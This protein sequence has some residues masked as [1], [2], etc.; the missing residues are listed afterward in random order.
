MVQESGQHLNKEECETEKVPSFMRTLL[1]V[2]LDAVIDPLASRGVPGQKEGAVGDT[3]TQYSSIRR[4]G[5][6]VMRSPV[7]KLMQIGP[8]S[9]NHARH[10]LSVGKLCEAAVGQIVIQLISVPGAGEESEVTMGDQQGGNTGRSL[11]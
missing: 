6:V 7:G 9:R 10:R 2:M 4:T 8:E 5:A 1:P 11:R 3:R